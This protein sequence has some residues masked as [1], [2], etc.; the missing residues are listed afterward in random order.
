MPPSRNINA[1]YIKQILTGEKELFK[2]DEVI[3]VKEIIHFKELSI[4]NL[5]T[6]Y[7][8][9][10]QAMKYLPTLKNLEKIDKAYFL[11]VI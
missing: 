6:T 5:L 10:E 1:L 9:W 4:K 11:T 3:H 2:T 7:P 8:K